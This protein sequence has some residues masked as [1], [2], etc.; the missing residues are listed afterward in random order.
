MEMEKE[1]DALRNLRRLEYQDYLDRRLLESARQADNKDD[2][3]IYRARIAARGQEMANARAEYAAV[4]RQR[5][6]TIPY[7]RGVGPTPKA[8]EKTRE[9]TETLLELRRVVGRLSDL[10]SR[11]TLSNRLPFSHYFDR[12]E[13]RS[14]GIY[15][16][17]KISLARLQGGGVLT[18]TDIKMWTD[19]VPSITSWQQADEIFAELQESAW[20]KYRNAI[21]AQGFSTT[22]SNYDDFLNDFEQNWE[23]PMPGFPAAP[24]AP[25]APRLQRSATSTGGGGGA[26]QQQQPPPSQPLDPGDLPSGY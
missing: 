2:V 12:D 18:D 9:N 21:R 26:Q 7:L 22:I 19:V 13:A 8:A 17:L 6:V 14:G 3:A 5:A 1:R 23:S 4:V 10:R 24:P 20:N 15:N 11:M 16:M 25:A